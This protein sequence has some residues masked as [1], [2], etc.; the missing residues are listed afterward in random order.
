MAKSTKASA[1]AA[2]SAKVKRLVMFHY[3]QDYSDDD[4]DALYASCRAA[5]D[6]RDGGAEIELVA[7]REGEE[8]E[9]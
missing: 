1:D 5:L 9:I 8:L 7:A 6:R 4:V 3:D 2:V